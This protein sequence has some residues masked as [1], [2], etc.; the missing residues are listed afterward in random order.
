MNRRLR[1]ILAV[2][3]LAGILAG[4]TVRL[5]HENRHRITLFFTSDRIETYLDG[6]MLNDAAAMPLDQPETRLILEQMLQSP[7]PALFL[8]YLNEVRF[9]DVQT[10]QPLLKQPPAPPSQPDRLWASG[11][12]NALGLGGRAG[13]GPVRVLTVPWENLRKEEFIIE[14]DMQ[15]PIGFRLF[16]KGHA[17]ELRTG[18][19]AEFYKGGYSLF[20]DDLHDRTQRHFI[21][22]RMWQDLM[23][24][25]A[26]NYLVN[27]MMAVLFVMLLFLVVPLICR[28]AGF[29]AKIHLL[30]RVMARLR[31]ILTRLLRT[32]YVRVPLEAIAIGIIALLIA[33]H[34]SG[35]YF[36]SIPRV[37]DEGIYLFQAKL[38]ADGHVDRSAAGTARKL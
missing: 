20:Q 23:H 3:L 9:L 16:R 25:L 29:S 17:T 2:P 15:L 24:M 31:P 36:Q 13:F 1:I 38:F 6:E 34:I 8:Q 19:S 30:Q 35:S 11:F 5:F 26:F 18:F 28:V 22:D 7:H 10:R 37:N 12:L 27:L 4:L 32:T 33:L 21:P 14:I